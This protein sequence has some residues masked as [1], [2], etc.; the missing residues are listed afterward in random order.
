MEALV[1]R[2][3]REYP[4]FVFTE[5]TIHCWSPKGQQIFYTADSPAG[6]L[7]EVAHARLGHQTYSSDMELIRKELEAWKEAMSLAELYDIAIDREYI[8]DCLDTYRDWLHKRSTCP[9]CLNNGLQQDS[10]HYICPNCG[11]AWH[12]SSARFCRPYRL[13]VAVDK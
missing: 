2:L 1:S 10:R 7:H 5:G 4:D 6:L 8:E 12:V 9:T 13:S 3:R 11:H